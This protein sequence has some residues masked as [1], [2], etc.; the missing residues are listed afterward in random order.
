MSQNLEWGGVRI[1]S[2]CLS[3]Q[4]KLRSISMSHYCLR[5]FWA[6][7]WG[8]DDAASLRS[9]EPYGLLSSSF[10]I[11]ADSLVVSELRDQLAGVVDMV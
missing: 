5:I 6:F 1:P 2:L 10:H 3:Q 11:L 9:N 8:S 4:D 7:R